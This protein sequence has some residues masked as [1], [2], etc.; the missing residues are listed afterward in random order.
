MS[1]YGLKDNETDEISHFLLR[2]AY[3]N[4]EENQQWFLKMEVKLFKARI[5]NL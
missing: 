4:S 2:V 3:Y 1:R 5:K